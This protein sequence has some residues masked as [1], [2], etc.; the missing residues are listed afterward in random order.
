MLTLQTFNNII[1]VTITM[2]VMIMMITIIIMIM[3]ND[4]DSNKE[5]VSAFEILDALTVGSHD[6]IIYITKLNKIFVSK[7]V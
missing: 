1:I 5:F 4:N 6:S 3:I 2:T 7:I